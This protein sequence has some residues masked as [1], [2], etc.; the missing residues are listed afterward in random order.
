MGLKNR[1][2]T[3]EFKRHV[4]R[5]V[6][7]GKRQAEIAREYQILPK[8]IS[9]WVTEYQ[10][11]AEQAFPGT[12]HPCSNAAREGA[13]VRENDRLRQENELLKKALA[14]LDGIPNPDRGNGSSA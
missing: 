5:Q 7:S 14:C 11:Y 1:Q 4:V 2:F 6:L 8:I 12:G 9:R 10:T 3:R 13:L